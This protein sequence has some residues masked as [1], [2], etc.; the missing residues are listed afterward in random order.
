MLQGEGVQR[1][2]LPSTRRRGAPAPG[3]RPGSCSA[4]N[5]ET[6]MCFQGRPRVSPP[7][8]ALV[9]HGDAPE[10]WPWPQCPG[11]LQALVEGGG[12][13]HCSCS[14]QGFVAGGEGTGFSLPSKNHRNAGVKGGAGPPRRPPGASR[15]CPVLSLSRLL[16]LSLPPSFPPSFSRLFC[17][18]PYSLSPFL[19]AIYGCLD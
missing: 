1:Q 11:H 3:N 14:E 16:P 15:A 18:L 7:C 6:A 9:S 5:V 8:R 10:T 17:P 12:W 13:T 4:G 19:S 2:C